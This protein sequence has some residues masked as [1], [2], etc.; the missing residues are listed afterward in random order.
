MTTQFETKQRG[1]RARFNGKD[2]GRA[3]LRQVPVD[4]IKIDHAY[5]R[6]TNSRWVNDHMPFDERRAGTLILSDRA[7]GPYC[8]DGG[9]RLALAKASGVHK[10]NAYVIEGLSQQ[11]EAELFSYYQRERRNLNSHD[12]FRADVAAQDPDTLAMVRIVN[13]AGFK[14]VD[15]AGSGPNNITAIDAC[16]YIQRYGG[17]DLLARTLDTVKSFWLGYEK[18]LHGQVLKG[19]AVFLHSA[20]E[21]AAF[22]QETFAKVMQGVVPLRVLGKAQENAAKRVSSSTSASDVAEAIWQ[23][24]NLKAA[25]DLRLTTLTISGRKRPVRGPRIGPNGERLS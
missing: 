6:G 18:A 16:R 22:R 2:I 20:G 21:Q 4:A 19:I 23:F 17:D 7:G 12:L 11:T 24:Y 8:I 9:H 13:N 25:K 3:E 10:A 14:L 15:K 1:F 5:Q